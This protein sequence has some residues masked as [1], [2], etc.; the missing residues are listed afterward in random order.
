MDSQ[1]AG[2]SSVMAMIPASRPIRVL[3]LGGTSE[4]SA[5]ASRLA[6]RA[7]IDAVLSFA[8][9]TENPK[10]P[11]IPYRVGG[12]GGV[13]GLARYLRET[14][15][16]RVIDATHPFAAQMSAHAVAACAEVGV[17]LMAYARAPWRAGPG[18]LF[19]EVESLEAASEALGPASRRVFLAIGRLH[20]PVFARAP[21][22]HY[23]VRL[24]DPP[25]E[26]VPLPNIDVL[27][28]RGPFRRDDDRA[29]LE[30]YRID[31]IV[32]KNA[33]GEAARAKIDAARD[34]GVPV[35]LVTPPAIPDRPTATTIEGLID[36]LETAVPR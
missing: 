20:L 3:I 34:L 17:P 1:G 28:A 36:W 14:A 9:R 8:G 4:A 23:V 2:V 21:Q 29:L 12:C 19:H 32:A 26:P 7:D 25:V 30:A 35:I 16:D 11:P 13:A 10:P 27:V 22:H 33:G 31:V 24:V 5:L 15:I 18:D 6:G